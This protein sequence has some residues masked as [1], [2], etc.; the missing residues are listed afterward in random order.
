MER[1]RSSPIDDVLACERRIVVRGEAGSGKTTLLQ[2]I[3]VATAGREFRGPLSLWNNTVPFFIR[4]RQVV[5]QGFPAPE[6]YVALIARDIAGGRPAG[7]ENEQLENGRAVVLIDG[8]DELPEGKREAFL[9]CLKELVDSYPHARYIITS[10]RTAVSERNWPDWHEWMHDQGFAEVAIQPMSNTAI[11]AFIDQ[12]HQAYADGTPDPDERADVLRAPAGLKRLL[13]R[14]AGLR[15]LA[16]NPLLCAMICALHYEKRSQLPAERIKLYEECIDML[17]AQ[18]DAGRGIQHEDYPDLRVKQKLALLQDLAYRMMRNGESELPLETVDDQLGGFL[19]RLGLDPGQPERIRA[20]FVERSN[21]LREPIEGQI[22][23][24]RRTFQE[25]FTA[26]E[27]ANGGEL[28]FLLK[29]AKNDQWRETITL[30]AGLL[31]PKESEKLLRGLLYGK[32]RA[33]QPGE[34]RQPARDPS[35]RELVLACLSMAVEMGVVIDSA[36]RQEVFAAVQDLFPPFTR[37]QQ[38]VVAAAGE[39]AIPYLRAE[40]QPNIAAKVACIET[41]AQIGGAK[42]LAAITEYA[43]I[44]HKAIQR[45]ID[46]VWS[47]FEPHSYAQKLLAQRTRIRIREPELLDAIACLPNL[48]SLVLFS[49]PVTDLSILSQLPRLQTLDLIGT[50]VMDLSVLAQLPSLQKLNL[51]GT[52]VTNLSALAQLPS[53]QTLALSGTSV[54]DLSVLAQLPSLQT[55]AL[56]GTSVMD[57]SVLAQLPSLQE[58]NLNS[59][60]VTDLSALAQ[61]PSLHTLRFFD[62]NVVDLSVLAQLPNLQALTLDGTLVMDLS[63]LTQLPNLQKLDLINTQMTDL[64]VLAHLPNL[65]SLTLRGTQVGDLSPLAHLPNLQSLDLSGTSVMDLSVLAQLP[66]LQTLDLIGTKVTDLS[67]LAQLLDLQKLT[68]VG[69]KVTDL[70]VLAQLSK[71]ERVI[72]VR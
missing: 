40:R 55:L 52:P 68:L 51:S 48:Q 14:R 49:I 26:K 58:L 31:R 23:F 63:V 30:A 66:S 28:G 5:E 65:Q 57:L 39:Q 60:P 2:W 29:K 20:F 8:V 35:R 7:W 17:L 3:A 33:P 1:R 62:T 54:M 43:A 16:A 12:W 21:L 69:T 24:T 11:A 67:V 4:L 25:F 44:D 34:S 70:R 9:E 37:E 53:L 47:G 50:S 61:L 41:L 59:T 64:S 72:I 36:L 13:P 32:Q 42:A 22:G 46:A 38:Q 56:S 6:Q 18:R 45:A 19:T 71:L 15:R 10:R 27:I